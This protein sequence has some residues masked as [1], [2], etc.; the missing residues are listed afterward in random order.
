MSTEKKDPFLDEAITAPCQSMVTLGSCTHG[1]KCVVAHRRMFTTEDG[2]PI[3]EGAIL[4]SYYD[5][6]W[7][8]I[9]PF[10][11]GIS[12]PGGPYFS[13]W[14]DFRQ[15]AVPRRPESVTCIDGSRLS[16]YAPCGCTRDRRC[17]S[18]AEMYGA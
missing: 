16:S 18:H 9:V 7:G 3:T 13:G 11:G 6:R 4:F 15:F 14:F 17:S 1:T 8:Q 5:C 2:A 12:Q 10:T